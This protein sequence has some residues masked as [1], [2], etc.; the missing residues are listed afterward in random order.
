MKAST[1]QIHYRSR[2]WVIMMWLILPALTLLTVW[3]E[4]RGQ[5]NDA[6]LRSLAM[7]MLINLLVLGCF[8]SLNIQIDDDGLQ[9]QFGLFG[10]P[11]WNLRW[12]DITHIEVCETMRFESRGIR[13]TREGM[14]YN[15]SGQGTVRITKADGS[16]I[17]LGSAEPEVLCAQIQHQLLHQQLLTQ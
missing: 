9:W 12:A 6:L 10:W 2:Q 3:F 4:M 16:K 13:L 17:R 8:A 5:E 11:K 1:P 7:V 14:L 15:A